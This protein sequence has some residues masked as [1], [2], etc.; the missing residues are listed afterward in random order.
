LGY[1]KYIEVDSKGS[2]IRFLPFHFWDEY[3]CNIK[4][5]AQVRIFGVAGVRTSVPF[6]S[7]PK[8][9]MFS[10]DLASS[11]KIITVR[12]NSVS[13]EDFEFPAQTQLWTSKTLAAKLIMEGVIKI[14][15]R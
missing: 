2:S 1:I 11:L 14:L 6:H 12:A 5:I 10:P 9:F 3:V 8:S 4:V 13:L 15:L 7:P